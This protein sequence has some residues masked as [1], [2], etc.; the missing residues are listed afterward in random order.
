MFDSMMS[1]KSVEYRDFPGHGVE[2]VFD[3]R[4]VCGVDV[5]VGAFGGVRWF[6]R[7][8]GVATGARFTEVDFDVQ[9]GFDVLP[10]G[11]ALVRSGS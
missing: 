10:A 6:V 7:W 3:D 4:E 8:W 2:V 1:S 11:Q 9:C 5:D